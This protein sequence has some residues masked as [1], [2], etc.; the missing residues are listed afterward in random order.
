MIKNR[1]EIIKNKEE[2]EEEILNF[3]FKNPQTCLLVETE[4]EKENYFSKGVKKIFSLKN[5]RLVDPLI[6]K[7]KNIIL[8]NYFFWKNKEQV[9]F[10]FDKK[11][12]PLFIFSDIKE[13]FPFYFILKM[14]EIKKNKIN[15]SFDFF[16]FF[17]ENISG[18]KK[19]ISFFNKYYDCFLTENNSEIFFNL[20]NNFLIEEKDEEVLL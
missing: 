3:L 2:R 8:D 20:K 9:F 10:C 19:N 6:F 5:K 13:K 4:E 16:R 17:S 15:R 11:N 12:I 7:E 1:I 14:R 18:S